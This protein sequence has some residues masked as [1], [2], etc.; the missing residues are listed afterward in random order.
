MLVSSRWSPLADQE[1][2]R[3]VGLCVTGPVRVEIVE[4]PPRNE[5]AHGP[6]ARPGRVVLAPRYDEQKLGE[7]E[8]DAEMVAGERD[9]GAAVGHVT[10]ISQESLP[11]ISLA[12]S[13][14]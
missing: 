6:Q 2:D 12:E 3:L 4:E 14:G 11:M 8:I 7:A 13:L 9:L 1:L 10:L 5:R